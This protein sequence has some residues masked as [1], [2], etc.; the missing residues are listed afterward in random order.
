MTTPRPEERGA[1]VSIKDVCL[2]AYSINFKPDDFGDD[3]ANT[4]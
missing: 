2:G 4:Y 1:G 3:E